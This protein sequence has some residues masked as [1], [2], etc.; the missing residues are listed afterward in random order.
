MQVGNS[1]TKNR[2][3]RVREKLEKAVK[4]LMP[5]MN[6]ECLSGMNLHEIRETVSI[7]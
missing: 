7:L 2:K 3:D 6:C 1:L 4:R 5:N